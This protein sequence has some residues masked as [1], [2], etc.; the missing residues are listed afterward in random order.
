MFNRYNKTPCLNQSTSCHMFS[1]P[2][3]SRYAGFQL[4]MGV[5]LSRWMVFME[6]PN[7]KWIKMDDNWGYPY[8]IVGSQWKISLKLMIL[9]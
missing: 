2:P 7:P 3:L 9:G 5:P 6:N 1:P 8:E 4:V